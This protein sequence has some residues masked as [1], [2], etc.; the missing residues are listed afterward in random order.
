MKKMKIILEGL[1]DEVYIQ[2]RDVLYLE[3]TGRCDFPLTSAQALDGKKIEEL[4]PSD[5]VLYT[6]KQ[7]LSYFLSQQDILDYLDY[8]EMKD[9]MLKPY[10]EMPSNSYLFQAMMEIY[11]ERSGL[12]ALPYPNLKEKSKCLKTYH[13]HDTTFSFYISS[14][15][16]QFFFFE[17]ND[18]L[19]ITEESIPRSFYEDCLHLASVYTFKEQFTFV[20]TENEERVLMIPCPVKE[21]TKVPHHKKYI[22]N[23][24]GIKNQKTGK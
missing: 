9:A 8:L 7:A 24:F 19:K 12:K 5:F 10:L 4:T 17:K 14:V 3:Q 16:P 18:H 2:K 20:P 15:I 11:M 6:G 1:Q 13:D 21:K 23:F 22:K